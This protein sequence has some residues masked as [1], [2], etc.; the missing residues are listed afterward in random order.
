MVCR[1]FFETTAQ[2]CVTR[3]VLG[4]RKF[5]EHI[6][7]ARTLEGSVSSTP[8]LQHVCLCYINQVRPCWVTDHHIWEILVSLSIILDSEER[9]RIP[10]GKGQPQRP[11][12]HRGRPAHTKRM[13]QLMEVYNRIVRPNERSSRAQTQDA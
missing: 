10:P 7:S 1:C 11:A 9:V 4:A 12:V 3:Q 6:Q 5:Q 13:V 2:F 8:R